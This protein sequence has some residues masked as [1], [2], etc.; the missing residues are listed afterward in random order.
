MG[1]L[2]NATISYSFRFLGFDVN[3][4]QND[5]SIESIFHYCFLITNLD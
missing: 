3:E 4:V 2:T 5:S 1:Y